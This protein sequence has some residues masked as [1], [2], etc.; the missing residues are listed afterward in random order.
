MVERTPAR[1]WL[2]RLVLSL[3]GEPKDREELVQLL[4]D[5]ERR[6]L[7]D[8]QA[9]GMIEGA[10]QVGEMQVRDIMIPRS[11][12]VVVERDRP[13]EE[14]VATVVESGHSRFP[15]IGES[16]D[17]VV[18]ILLAKDLL[19]YFA[20]PAGRFSMRD[21]MRPAVFVP[22]SKRLNV[23]LADFRASRN[24]MAVVVDEYSGVSGLVTIE[25]VLEQIVGEID[26]EHDTD[27]ERFVKQLRNGDYLVKARTPIDDFNEYFET[28]L[29]A[30]EFD[31]IGG[32]VLKE[33]GYLPARGDQCEVAGLAI[34][35]LRADQRRVHLLRIA[36]RDG[37]AE[38]AET[39]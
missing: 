34:T 1:P 11:E 13:P 3:T 20:E 27:D 12:M 6:E 28:A 22:E 5:A 9:L 33:F 32:L 36:T 7:V 29:V 16:R 15:V 21:A 37:G 31:T 23:L 4:R 24:H 8:G 17:E 19:S 25:D 10:L 30:E 2:E 18:G 14:F 35:V 38:A 39:S 26:D